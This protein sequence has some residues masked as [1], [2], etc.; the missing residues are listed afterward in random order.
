MKEIKSNKTQIEHNLLKVS[1]I[2]LMALVMLVNIVGA[3]P[4]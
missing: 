2:A 4:F 1:G 3:V